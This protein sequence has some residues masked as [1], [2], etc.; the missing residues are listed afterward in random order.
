MNFSICTIS[1]DNN[2]NSNTPFM[3]SDKFRN[4][5]GYKDTNDFPHILSS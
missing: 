2:V 5:L 3:W 1:E 4:M